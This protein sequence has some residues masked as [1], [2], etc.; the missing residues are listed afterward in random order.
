MIN[1]ADLPAVRSQL[2][3]AAAASEEQGAR[4]AVDAVEPGALRGYSVADL[5]AVKA[6]LARAPV[7]Q[8]IEQTAQPT[9]CSE[10]IQAMAGDLRINARLWRPPGQCTVQAENKCTA[11]Q[12]ACPFRR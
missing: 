12:Q 9:K 11:D 7:P 8:G 1:I 4:P 5:P 3:R 6:Q 10:I 2:E